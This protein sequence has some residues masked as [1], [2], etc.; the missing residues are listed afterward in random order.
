MDEDPFLLLQQYLDETHEQD[1]VCRHKVTENDGT[2]IVCKDCSQ[3][4]DNISSQTEWVSVKGYGNQ[5]RCHRRTTHDKSIFKDVAHIDFPVPIIFEANRIYSAVTENKT[6]R[7]NNRSAIIFGCIFNAYKYSENPQS[8]EELKAKFPL[9]Q[10]VISKGLKFVSLNIHKYKKRRPVYITAK[11][12]I[13]VIMKKMNA[14][15]EDIQKVLGLYDAIKNKSDIL[16]RSRPQSTAIS[17]IFY[18]IQE[19][20]KDISLDTYKS[21]VELSEP[22]IIKIVK[23]IKKILAAT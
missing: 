1:E 21:V 23:E 17:L 15:G 13:P 14:S 3:L 2:N 19:T 5:T 6:H 8:L 10:K 16:T 9:E 20:N 11:N 7:A 18:Y 12:I 22:T 4:L